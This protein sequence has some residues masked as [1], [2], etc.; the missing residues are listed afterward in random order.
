MIKTLLKELEGNKGAWRMSSERICSKYSLDKEQIENYK[1]EEI[2]K[3]VREK[4]TKNWRDEMAT[5]SSLE[6]YRKHKTEIKQEEMYYN[7]RKSEIWFRL[8]TNCLF[9]KKKNNP[10]LCELCG[11]EN[12][13]IKHFL[14]SCDKLETIRNQYIGLQ[15]P[16]IEDTDKILIELI[17]NKEDAEDKK[18]LIEKMWNKRRF[19]IQQSL[20]SR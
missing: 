16:H 19:I 6:L 1:K 12:E 18:D 4:E 8:K 7:D 20:T 10:N 2:T 13:D 3:K 17:Y 9:F 15:R 11:K 5:K 14:L